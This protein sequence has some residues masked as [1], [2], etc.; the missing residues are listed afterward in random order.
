M[1]SEITNI[2]IKLAELGQV[3]K[4]LLH[5]TEQL[6]NCRAEYDAK[7]AKAMDEIEQRIQATNT[8]RKSKCDQMLRLYTGLESRI[9]T[10]EIMAAE[11]YTRIET[12]ISTLLEKSK[13]SAVW[14]AL[15]ISGLSFALHL[16]QWVKP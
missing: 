16:L 15:L 5:K 14:I 10:D 7:V 13:K 11:R 3:T 6:N 1:D 8:E 4:Q 12:N 9:Q 2:R